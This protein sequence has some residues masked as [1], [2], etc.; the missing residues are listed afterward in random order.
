MGMVLP[1]GGGADRWVEEVGE[2]VRVGE[3][4]E[5]F[6]LG[7]AHRVADGP[8]LVGRLGLVTTWRDAHPI[9]VSPWSQ[10]TRGNRRNVAEDST[11]VATPVRSK[12]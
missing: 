7:G 5:R 9:S 4:L 8:V 1:A 3:L 10:R 2:V 12:A 6:D 11:T